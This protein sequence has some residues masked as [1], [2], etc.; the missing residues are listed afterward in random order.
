MNGMRTNFLKGVL[1]LAAFTLI[2]CTTTEK[3]AT[4]GGL[5]GATL[6]GIIG[7]Q[8]GN[9]PTGAAIGAAVGTIGGLL[10]GEHMEKNEQKKFCPLCGAEYGADETY[11]PKDGTELKL[12]Q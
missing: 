9:G 3:A 2:G 11:C 6:G 5:G 8:S 1:I 10:V 7:H 4:V 12:K